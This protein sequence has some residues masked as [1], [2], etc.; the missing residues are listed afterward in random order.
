MKIALIGYKG[1]T[2]SKVYQELLD[3]NYEVIGIDKEGILLSKVIND[4][5]LVIDFTNKQSALKHIFVCLDN[6]KPFIVGTTGFS[7]DELAVIKSRCNLLKVKG[8]ICYNFS[9]PLLLIIKMIKPLSDHFETINYFDIHHISKIDKVSGTTYLFMLQ[10]SKIKLKSYKTNKNNIT[11]VVQMTSK[12][13]KLVLSYQVNDKIVFA[14]GL[15]NYLK[16]QD[17]SMIINLL[18]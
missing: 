3:N 16:S 12:Y 8:V 1:K 4:V 2:G 18:E 15:V 9:L 7:Y 13:D 14:K 5:D 6:L 17:D 11:Y 10:N